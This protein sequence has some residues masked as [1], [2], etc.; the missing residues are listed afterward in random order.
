MQSPTKTGYNPAYRDGEE[1]ATGPKVLAPAEPFIVESGTRQSCCGTTH[2][3]ELVMPSPPADGAARWP[4]V[5][6]L[7]DWRRSSF[8]HRG[9]AEM[10]ARNGLAV[11][12]PQLGR[13]NDDASHVTSVA[14]LVDHC[15][16]LCLRSACADDRTNG[17]FDAKQ[18]VLI[19]CGTGAAVVL[20][21]ASELQK[22]AQ[23]P[24][25]PTPVGLLLLGPR[26][27][28]VVKPTRLRAPRLFCAM[29]TLNAGVAPGQVLGGQL[30]AEQLV[31][32]LGFDAI[33]LTV[34]G[35]PASHEAWES[36]KAVHTSS[37]L[38]HTIFPTSIAVDAALKAADDGKSP[39]GSCEAPMHK[40]LVQSLVAA[41]AADACGFDDAVAFDTVV[42][43]YAEKGRIEVR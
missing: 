8:E 23:D 32:E 37:D 3:Y 11:L 24:A 22:C 26:P 35:A 4:V 5:L 10:L 36:Q 15:R 25:L 13:R 21:A 41:F 6:L 12:L 17:S 9:T 14:A 43:Y 20:D 7:H 1:A 38:L 33:L 29:Q 31:S 40:M 39:F 42:K 28:S 2:N 18:V 16:W 30:P 34:L 27:S 19:G